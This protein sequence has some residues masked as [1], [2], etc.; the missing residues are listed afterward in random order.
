MEE[1][2]VDK[3]WAHFSARI[4]SALTAP[5]LSALD[6]CN[7]SVSNIEFDELNFTGHSR[8]KNPVETGK[9]IQFIKL[10][11]SNGKIAKTIADRWWDKLPD[12]YLTIAWCLPENLKTNSQL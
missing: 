9:I 6:F 10:D 3:N 12:D 7:S 1:C 5:Y 8:Q 4:Q 2:R 11:I